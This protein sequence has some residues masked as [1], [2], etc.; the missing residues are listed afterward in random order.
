VFHV[1]PAGA[2]GGPAGFDEFVTDHFAAPLRATAR[3]R[4]QRRLAR[5]PIAAAVTTVGVLVMLLSTAYF[6]RGRGAIPATS[7]EPDMRTP[8]CGVVSLPPQFV[9]GRPVANRIGLDDLAQRVDDGARAGFPDVYNGLALDAD[10]SGVQVAPG[11]V[12]V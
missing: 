7:G 1:L 12:L 5:P 3:A 4:R 11:I 2:V 9:H 10:N 6:G 8:G